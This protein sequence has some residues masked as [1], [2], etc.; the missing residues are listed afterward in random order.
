MKNILIVAYF[1][2][3]LGG[4]GVQR[5]LKF[6]KFLKKFGYN[7]FVLT[8]NNE[9]GTIKDESL[10]LESTDGIKVFRAIQKEN[11]I[12]NS[13]LNRKVTDV[14]IDNKENTIKKAP[15]TTLKSRIKRKVKKHLLNIYRN[16]YIPDDKISWKKDAVRVGLKIIK[17]EKI[18]IIYS[19]SAPYTGHLIAYE[20]KQKSNL[21]WIADFRD[22]WV[23]NPFVNY[24]T[25]A[26]IKNEKM[27]KMVIEK[28][29]CVISVSKPI[30]DEFV[31][32]YKDESVEKFKVITNGYDEEDF[33]G[34]NM[35]FVAKKYI[36]THNGTLYG[37]RSPKNF[38]IAI[39]KL[40]MEKKIKQDELTIRFVGQIG[41]DAQEDIRFFVAKYD[42]IIEFISY[43]PHKESLKKL[44]ES[45]ATLLI[46]E[47]G[48]GSDGIYT[49]KLFEYIRSGRDIIGIVPPGVA[50]D[51]IV[52]TNTGFCCHPE[53]VDEIEVA[54]YKSYCIW[55]GMQKKTEVNWEKVSEYSRENL[56][57][58][59]M[60]VIES[61]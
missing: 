8:V 28:A 15:E 47:A 26:K 6:A 9:K 14:K 27:E 56:T 36:I 13:I 60:N 35:N 30:I 3:P 49:G 12:V 46:I 4:A 32:R 38:L 53:K 7:V 39:D 23:A 31:Y 5:T 40:I 24:S 58:D 59:L 43:L 45:T 21:P 44:E 22:Q 1:Y 20:L 29:D 54:I 34:F 50:R 17:D 18:D 41:K 51:L 16:M 33:A 48:V 11:F 25:Y 61:L 55:K 19:T 57:R 2:P 10:K 37:K 42:N 52:N